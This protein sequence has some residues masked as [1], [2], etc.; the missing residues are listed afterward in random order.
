MVL[1]GSAFYAALVL[2]APAGVHASGSITPP[3]LST[4][5]DASLVIGQPD[6]TSALPGTSAIGLSWPRGVAFDAYGDMWVPDQSNNRILEFVPPFSDGMSASLVLG[7]SGFTANTPGTGRNSLKGPRAVAFD[8]GGDLWVADTGN[9]RILEFVPPFTSGMSASLVIGQTSFTGGC[10]T[11]CSVWGLAFDQYGNL[12]A[13]NSGEDTILEFTSPSSDNLSTT[14]SLVFGPGFAAYT[15]TCSSSSPTCLQFVS[16][17]GIAFDSY[18]NMY[19]ADWGNNRTLGFT[20]DEYTED[21]APFVVIGQPDLAT[22]GCTTSQSGLASQSGLCGPTGVAFDSGGNLWVADG[23]N[24]RL[25]EFEA[26]G[27][28]D[29]TPFTTG[30]SAS[31]VIGQPD[32]TSSASETTQSGLWLSTGLSPT[33]VECITAPA[34]APDGTLWMGDCF[35][36]RILQFGPAPTVVSCTSSSF[37]VGETSACT[38]TVP[39]GSSPSGT[40]TF[41]QSSRVGAV[42]FPSPAT[43]LLASGS[44]FLTVTGASA[45]NVTI[46]AT[47]SGNSENLGSSGSYTIGIYTST[48]TTLSR[49]SASV[50]Q[51]STGVSVVITG[52]TG[53]AVTISSTNLGSSQPSGTTST[54]LDPHFFDVEVSGITGG[55][56][57]VYITD[58]AVTPSSVMEYWTGTGWSNPQSQEASSTTICGEIPVS[59]LIGTPIVIGH[60]AGDPSNED[61]STCS[62]LSIP[63]ISASPT[64]ILS[65]QSSTLSTITSFS[66]GTPPYT[67]QWL[68]EAP[69]AGSYSNLGGPISCKAGDTPSTLTNA[70][71]TTG[72]W[73]FELQVTDSFAVPPTVTSNAVT[74]TANTVTVVCSPNPDAVGTLTTCTAT[75]TLSQDSTGMVTFAGFGSGTVGINPCAVSSG[76]CS[77]TY[78]PASGA[79]GS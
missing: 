11:F 48:L 5:E 62:A 27:E 72:T 39:G 47:Y 20:P 9:D 42:T 73:S 49:G 29:G 68:Q 44:C 21:L 41:S 24:N 6:F 45:G 50:S 46:L 37:A 52:T 63:T 17:V 71:S 67:C 38:A 55:T 66:G 7:Q 4:G 69:G 2:P 23:E 31:V 15:V 53:A 36:N 16:P 58:T 64:A 56:A 19:V 32:F 65:G 60:G 70:L 79:E 78:R 33:S 12:W 30:M 3:P 61:P 25:M 40:V 51:P 1:M 75:T 22:T 77:T 54:G 14:A 8:S 35:N 10:V 18:G 74:I 57:T 26:C 76:S 43:C 13:T 28:C 34:F 59:A